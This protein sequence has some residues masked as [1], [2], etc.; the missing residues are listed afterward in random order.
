LSL[1]FTSLAKTLLYGK[2]SVRFFIGILLSFAFSIS[3]ILSTIGIM[4]GFQKTLKEG[5]FRSGGDFILYRHDG[6]FEQE[7]PLFSE[8]GEDIQVTP[9]IQSEGFLVAGEESQGI[10]LRGVMSESFSKVTG[11]LFDIRNNDICLGREI[12]NRYGLK[13]GHEVVL[14][15]AAGVKDGS[16]LPLLSRFKVRCVVDHGIYKK[17]ERMVYVNLAHLQSLLSYE[18]RV[19]MMVGRIS[20]TAENRIQLVEDKI[21]ELY[22]TVGSDW[23]IKP[24]WSEFSSLIEAVEIEKVSISIILQLVVIISIFNITAFVIFI[25][26]RKA[27]EIFLFRSLGARNKDLQK[28]WLWFMLVLWVMS[29]SLSMLLVQVFEW[30]LINLE[31]LQ[32]PGDVYVLSHLQILLSPTDYILTFLG[33]LVWLM[34]LIGLNLYRLK[35]TPLLQGLRREFS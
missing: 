15:F 16:S 17:D 32:I 30:L 21:V 6:Y 9:L 12:A 2:S 4:D 18:N 19:N 26:E 8:L 28:F 29:C 27:Q 1:A 33:A 13:E 25:N 5:L 7:N 24:F 22:D 34:L 11:L 31:S 23:V 14:T 20:K 3:V 35:K 10:L